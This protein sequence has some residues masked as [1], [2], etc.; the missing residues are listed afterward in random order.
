MGNVR[1][2]V[3][4][5]NYLPWL[6]FFHKI[7]RVDIF[8]LLD[9]VQFARRGYTHRVHVMGPAKEALWITQSIRKR[10]V[11]E[12]VIR[13]MM[14]ADRFWVDKHL[15]TLETSY[16]KAAHFDAVFNLLEKGLRTENDRLAQFNGGLIQSI[17]GAVG[18]FTPILYA[19]DLPVD[20]AA[21]PSERIARI[22]Q[23][24]GATRY[25]SG[26][27]ARAYNDAEVFARYG[28]TLA[29][30]DFR[31]SPYPQRG[32]QGDEAFVGGLSIV[33]ALFNLGFD[34]VAA[35]FREAA[36]PSSAPA[37]MSVQPDERKGLM[38]SL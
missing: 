5:P 21:S 10:A 9:N 23:H 6:G 7:S 13:D 12:Q 4:Q 28:V 16:G 38:H 15:R 20:D 8:V 3:H 27:G 32:I 19:S 31:V 30:N 34:R 37:G 11:E 33:D 22:A 18:I 1:L 25:L 17:C 35:M 36:S 24:L 2:A 14:F 26:A 29:Y